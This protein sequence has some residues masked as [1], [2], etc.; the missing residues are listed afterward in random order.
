MLQQR[1][2]GVWTPIAF[3][4]RKLSLAEKKYSTFDK[5]LPAIYMAVKKFRFFVEGPMHVTLVSK[6]FVGVI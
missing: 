1:L 2:N 3:F 4:S 5:E 6:N